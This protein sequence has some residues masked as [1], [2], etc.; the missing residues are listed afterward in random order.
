MNSTRRPLLLTLTAFVLLLAG[1]ALSAGG[2]WLFILG[3]TPL[4]IAFGLALMLVAILLFKQKALAFFWYAVLLGGLLWWSILEQGFDWWPLAAR[5]GL[6]FVVGLWLLVPWVN[7]SLQGAPGLN[8]GLLWLALL[9]TLVVSAA[10]WINDPHRIDGTLAM[11]TTPDTYRTPN[12]PKEEWHAYGRT[13]FGQ[14]YSPL[15]Q[16]TPENIGQLEVAWH[17]KTGD[18]RG[19][20]GDPV[21]TT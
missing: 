12:V 1:L 3:D 16:I 4:Y 13:G 8:K 6:F 7:R 21:E 18:M 15:E 11:R 14:R 17:Y 9:G 5:V 10:S 19:Q 2:L 20:P